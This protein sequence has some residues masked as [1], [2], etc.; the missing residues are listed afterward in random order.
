MTDTTARRLGVA[1]ARATQLGHSSMT[2]SIRVG[3]DTWSWILD[4]T[5]PGYENHLP[6]QPK[7]YGIDIA[8]DQE[9]EPDQVV[10]RAEELIQ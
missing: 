10:V 6:G 1:H 4:H 9:L 2:V 5:L 3:L 8:P 7:L